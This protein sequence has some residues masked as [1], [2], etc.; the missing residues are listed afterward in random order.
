MHSLG[1]SFNRFQNQGGSAAPLSQEAHAY[2]LRAEERSSS[3]S[4]AGSNSEAS[5]LDAAACSRGGS[6]GACVAGGC[7]R[8]SALGRAD[9]GGDATGGGALLAPAGIPS[10]IGV[11]R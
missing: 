6:A 5:L 4:I 2:C 9:A 7:V 8:R 1:V 11:P 3:Q 10:W